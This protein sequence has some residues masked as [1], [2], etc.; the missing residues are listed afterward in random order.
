MSERDSGMLQNR[1]RCV[2]CRA[3]ELPPG[4]RVI[5][6]LGGHSLGDCVAPRQVEIAMAEGAQVA[7]SL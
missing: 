7:R 2:T 5:V 4:S 1:R 6:D 3:D